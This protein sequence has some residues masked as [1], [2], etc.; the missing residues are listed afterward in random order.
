MHMKQGTSYKNPVTGGTD[1]YD[2]SGRLTGTSYENKLTGGV[3]HYDSQG[4]K[5]GTS[6]RNHMT[7]G[8][9]HYGA[10]GT[11]KGSSYHNH[12]TGGTDYYGS[13]GQ[14]K[15]SAYHNSI[16]GGTDY[17]SDDS[18]G[19]VPSYQNSGTKQPEP[20][21]Y[22]T[23]NSSSVS[24]NELNAVR[25]NT[26]Y[27]EEDAKQYAVYA[28]SLM[29]QRGIA[30]DGSVTEAAERT[31]VHRHG[32]L[33]LFS[34]KKKEKIEIPSDRYFLLK[35][36]TETDN[37]IDSGNGEREDH[38][39]T[40]LSAEGNVLLGE[41]REYYRSN[42]RYEKRDT[43]W[44][45]VKA[46]GYITLIDLY[47]KN[48]GIPMNIGTYMSHGGSSVYKPDDFWKQKYLDDLNRE[49]QN[50]QKK[51]VT[52]NDMSYLNWWAGVIW[53]LA[54]AVLSFVIG[55]G[56]R[57]IPLM[58]LKHAIVIT[59]MCAYG[60]FRGKGIG[61]LIY[62]VTNVDDRDIFYMVA[63]GI[64]F[65]LHYGYTISVTRQFVPS[66]IAG[67]VLTGISFLVSRYVFYPK[68]KSSA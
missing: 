30:F 25:N 63:A 60:Y 26:S 45:P 27:T 44:T 68:K 56:S 36:D 61:N 55:Y 5:T 20:K 14:K 15:G 23:H 2:E 52:G 31:A 42:G 43:T 41:Y 21:P 34:S 38:S 22:Y 51:H 13:D 47:L 32:P 9:D 18:Y 24:Q 35:N 39:L 19:A 58:I 29:I 67:A 1:H 49:R 40:V 10:D 64:S 66:L 37:H 62:T 54:C 16:T 8:V 3:D 53:Y 50:L 48:H 46:S 12:M 17:Y 28:A 6:Y 65:F 7:G 57:S 4:N 33:N 59:G 11:K